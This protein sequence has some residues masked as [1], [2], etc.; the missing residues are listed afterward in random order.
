MDMVPPH[1]LARKVGMHEDR[2]S[3]SLDVGA[4]GASYQTEEKSC[5]VYV[6]K[7]FTFSVAPI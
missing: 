2:A 5:G 7:W 1:K 3:G 6:R 4:F